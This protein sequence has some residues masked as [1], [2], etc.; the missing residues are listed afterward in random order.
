MGRMILQ[1]CLPWLAWLAAAFLAGYLLVRLNRSRVEL[2]RLRRLHGDQ[3]G[4][5]QSLSFVLTL[6]F[7]VMIMLFIVQV[8]Q[9]MIGTIVVHYAAFAAARS[10]V[11]WIPARLAPPEQE[12]CISAHFEDPEAEEQ[13]R[14]ILDPLDP[15]YGPAAGGVTYV[16]APGSPKYEKIASA[17]VLGCMPISPSRD[18]GLSAPRSGSLAAEIIKGAYGSM[19]PGSAANAMIPAR[20]ENKLAYA[21]QN[22][23][24]E[25]RFYHK[26]SEPPLVQYFLPDDHG[27]FYFNQ[28]GWQD[29]ITVTVRYNL[30]LLP[31]PGRLLARNVP[32]PGG[33]P[34][35]VS[36]TIRRVGDVY[37][38]PLEA[39]AT[40]GN[41]GEQS[42]IPYEYQAY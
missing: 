8:S 34:D 14:P 20:L 18:L 3:D 36:G 31:G 6:P 39:S 41:E 19:A 29:P 2:R 25:I 27:E 12:N 37:V 21:M 13:V 9:L 33:A 16:V 5:A 7:F 26:N 35:E 38:Y 22:T 23:T 24:V 15:D 4:T 42:V 17:A 40:L 32:G 11:V 30:A 28:L 10:A 1:A